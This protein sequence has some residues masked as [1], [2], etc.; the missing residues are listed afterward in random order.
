MWVSWLCYVLTISFSTFKLRN[1]FS[2]IYVTEN[3]VC[4]RPKM[5]AVRSREKEL[6]IESYQLVTLL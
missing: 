1:S 4:Y 3:N 5:I 2:D 6:G